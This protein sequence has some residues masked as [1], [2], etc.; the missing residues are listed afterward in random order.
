MTNPFTTLRNWWHSR[1]IRRRW[2][3]APATLDAAIRRMLVEVPTAVL[4]EFAAQPREDCITGFGFGS[5]MGLRN[6]WGLWHGESGVSRELREAGVVHGDDQSA[7]IF[8]ALW[9][10]L[11]NAPFDLAEEAHYYH[12]YWKAQGCNP[13]GSPLSR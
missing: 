10:R 12:A 5:G 4:T 6:S 9:C 8:T 2:A 1:S 11:N 3:E 7:V 13:D